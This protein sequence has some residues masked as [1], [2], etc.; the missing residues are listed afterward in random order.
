MEIKIKTPKDLTPFSPFSTRNLRALDPQKTHI[1]NLFVSSTTQIRVLFS[2]ACRV[3]SNCSSIITWYLVFAK[4]DD[5][6]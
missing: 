1:H 3:Y 4:L 6:K 5:L 2:D